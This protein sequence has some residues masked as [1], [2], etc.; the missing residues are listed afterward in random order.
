MSEQAQD[1]VDILTESNMRTRRERAAFV[2]KLRDVMHLPWNQIGQQVNV[3]PQR[4]QQLYRLNQYLKRSADSPFA[5]LSTRARHFLNNVAVSQRMPDDWEQNP[6][7]IAKL[8]LLLRQMTRR[9]AM[10]YRQLGPRT[11]QEIDTF[12]RDNGGQ[13]FD[14]ELVEAQRF[15][16]Q[17]NPKD[18]AT[19]VSADIAVQ[20]ITEFLNRKEM[21]G[22][23]KVWPK[24]T[25]KG[26][27]M[28]E[29]AFTITL[30][31]FLADAWQENWA[32]V[33]EF[34]TFVRGLGFGYEM[35][36][37]STLHFFQEEPYT[38]VPTQPGA[39]SP[40]ANLNID[41]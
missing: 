29:G 37:P 15:S 35:A 18:Y 21:R 40:R 23:F 17:Y 16:P 39:E 41:I 19:S 7:L 2:A 22:E 9:G 31:G 33:G 5:N 11:Y 32:I 3:T 25:Y 12:L 8:S 28:P 20:R 13:G 27:E 30:S 10:R 14:S 4:A 36:T 26:G 6:E 34:D 24:G 38:A 1:I